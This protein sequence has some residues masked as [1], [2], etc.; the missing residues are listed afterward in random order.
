MTIQKL[1]TGVTVNPLKMHT[2][3]KSYSEARQKK[4]LRFVNRYLKLNPGVDDLV[5]MEAYAKRC[6]LPMPQ[7]L[8]ETA[9]EIIGP[10]LTNVI[11]ALLCAWL[12]TYF[13]PK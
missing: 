11:I 10:V 8:Y 5:L 3:P 4:Y 6:R 13:L 9:C 1:A 2:M 12:S 7:H